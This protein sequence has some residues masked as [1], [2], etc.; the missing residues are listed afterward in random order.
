[1]LPVG[2]NFYTGE[3]HSATEDFPV[4]LEFYIWGKVNNEEWSQA[5][6]A[7]DLQIERRAVGTVSSTGYAFFKHLLPRPLSRGRMFWN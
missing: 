6:A 3:E 2:K 4:P 1:M 7:L 5:L